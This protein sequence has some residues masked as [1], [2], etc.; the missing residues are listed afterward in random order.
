MHL[1][2]TAAVVANCLLMRIACMRAG[3]K[4][5]QEEVIDLG[6]SADEKGVVDA[7]PMSERPLPKSGAAAVAAVEAARADRSRREVARKTWKDPVEHARAAAAARAAVENGAQHADEQQEQAGA[8]DGAAE[9][10]EEQAGAKGGAKRKG[11]IAGSEAGNNGSM[12][13]R[14]LRS[15]VTVEVED[16]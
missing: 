13:Q 7:R 11:G 8:P 14:R 2:C 9:K 5:I 10:E 6:S 3:K 15:G 12:K 16:I 1:G 4:G